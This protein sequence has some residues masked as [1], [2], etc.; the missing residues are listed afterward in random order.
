[1]TDSGNRPASFARSLRTL[2]RAIA[3]AF[4]AVIATL[5]VGAA[6]ASA[7]TR[8]GFVLRIT[9][10]SETAT[11]V[12][13]TSPAA[14]G[15]DISSTRVFVVAVG[16]LLAPERFPAGKVMLCDFENLTTGS[17][18]EDFPFLITGAP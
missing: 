16:A 18:F 7:D 3:A 11:I 17:S 13:P 10:G 6:S 12:S 14:V 1:V 9:C 15:Q 2:K 5:F 8:T 4:A